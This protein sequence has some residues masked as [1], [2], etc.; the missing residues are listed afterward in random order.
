MNTCD[1]YNTD[2]KKKLNYFLNCGGREEIKEKNWCPEI[3]VIKPLIRGRE[4]MEKSRNTKLP[5]DKS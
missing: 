3:Y 4:D 5:I 1:H 2:L